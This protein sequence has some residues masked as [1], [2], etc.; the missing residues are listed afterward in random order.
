MIGDRYCREIDVSSNRERRGVIKAEDFIH[1]RDGY[2]ICA[3]MGWD[4]TGL[5]GVVGD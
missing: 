4:G 2:Y 5:M 3:G 1:N